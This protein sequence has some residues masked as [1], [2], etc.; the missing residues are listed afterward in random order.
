MSFR[1]ASMFG[2][3]K[4]WKSRAYLDWVKSQPCCICG[5]P[6]D[7]PHHINMPGKGM[8]SKHPDWATIPLCRGHHDAAHRGEVHDQDALALWT[9]GQ[10]IAEGV[11]A[12]S[13]GDRE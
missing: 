5:L 6:A 1:Q 12:L 13:K 9:L 4:P 11:F 10:A 2:Y 8:G 3:V 7:D